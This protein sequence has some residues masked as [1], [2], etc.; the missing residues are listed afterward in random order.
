MPLIPADWRPRAATLVFIERSPAQVDAGADGG[1]LLIRKKRGH[2]AGKVNAPGGHIEP[3]ET[4]HECA[5]REVWEEVGLRCGPLTPAALL[6]FHD[7]ENGFDMRGF[8]FHAESFAG[9][10]IET[11]EAVPFWCAWNAVPFDEMWEDDR[12]WL[13]SIRARRPV[14]ADLLFE[15]DRLA[16][17]RVRPV[18]PGELDAFLRDFAEVG[19]GQAPRNRAASRG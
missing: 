13:P 15:N 6:R 14:R 3:D 12:Y 16:S 10:P 4:P 7:C 8:A 18:R 1:V 11:D 19:G 9:D 17:R 2:G 5:V